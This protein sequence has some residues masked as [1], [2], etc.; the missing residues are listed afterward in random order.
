MQRLK[1][2]HDDGAYVCCQDFNATSRLIERGET[3]DHFIQKVSTT[4]R[5]RR[6]SL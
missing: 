6:S 2:L 5:S 4:K 1:V 3:L